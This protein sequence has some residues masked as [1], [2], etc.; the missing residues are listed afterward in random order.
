MVGGFGDT[1][2]QAFRVRLQALGF[3]A[4]T[5][6]ATRAAHHLA[7]QCQSRPSHATRSARGLHPRFLRLP[8]SGTLAAGGGGLVGF[9]GWVLGQSPPNNSFKPK[10]NRYA[11]V[12][13]LTQ[14]LGRMGSLS[15][16]YIAL[17]VGL[18]AMLF[19][20][21]SLYVRWVHPHSRLEPVFRP[22]WRGGKEASRFG[23]AAQIFAF[24]AI[25]I[26]LVGFGL[27]GLGKFVAYWQYVVYS[28]AFIA[29]LAF[30]RES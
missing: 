17:L 3:R 4:H 25:G 2:H 10:T 15:I 12:F 26:F 27:W 28:A 18:L 20:V 8:A 13:G 30:L 23:A 5:P 21:L 11:I 9:S 24:F 16:N 29:G 1:T 22:R 7:T 14:A 6:P 19:G